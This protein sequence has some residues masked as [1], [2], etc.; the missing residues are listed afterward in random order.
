MCIIFESVLMPFTLN[1]RNQPML[2]ETAACQNWLVFFETQCAVDH[3]RVPSF[4][5][6]RQNNEY[7]EVEK[8]LMTLTNRQTSAT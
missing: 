2:V 8:S 1:Y 6:I 3:A 5:R 7:I 4:V